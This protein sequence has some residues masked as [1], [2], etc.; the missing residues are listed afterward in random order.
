MNRTILTLALAC[1]MAAGAVFAQT[2]SSAGTTGHGPMSGSYGSDWSMSL[3]PALFGED[4]TTLRS[5]TEITSQWGTLSEE[6]RAMLRR[7]CLAH[8]DQSAGTT[9]GTTGAVGATGATA[10]TGATADISATDT[11]AGASGTVDAGSPMTVSA[12]QMERICMVTKD[13]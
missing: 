2:E 6:D 4:G 10:E 5:D 11:T 7:D 1:Q 13:L 8:S 3:G 9:E 12:E